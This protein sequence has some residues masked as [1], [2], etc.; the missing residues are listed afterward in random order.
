M[1]TILA[2]TESYKMPMTSMFLSSY[3]M[4]PKAVLQPSIPCASEPRPALGLEMKRRC[5]TQM[6]VPHDDAYVVVP[7]PS[8]PHLLKKRALVEERYA[9]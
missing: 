5:P 6:L 1:P 2:G 8:P 4:I 9:C 3:L 7:F